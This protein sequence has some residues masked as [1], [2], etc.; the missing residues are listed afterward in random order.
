MTLAG[1]RKYNFFCVVVGMKACPA[2]KTPDN[3]NIQVT[4]TEAEF[5]SVF[6]ANRGITRGSLWRMLLVTLSFTAAASSICVAVGYRPSETQQRCEA[7]RSIM[8]W[9][10]TF[11]Y[12]FSF[13]NIFQSGGAAKFPWLSGERGLVWFSIKWLLYRTES[14]NCVIFNIS[15]SKGETKELDL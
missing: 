13:S 12:L 11:I 6:G 4:A 7:D 3:I 14:N 1:E 15:P 9:S 8:K 10:P 5:L 2:M